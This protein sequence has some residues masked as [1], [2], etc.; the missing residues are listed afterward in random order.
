MDIIGFWFE[1][2]N[3]TR[4]EAQLQLTFGRYA[5]SIDGVLIREGEGQE[6]TVS[7]RLG[8]MPRRI[9]WPDDAVF[10]TTD[11]KT[12]DAWLKSS[13]HKDAGSLLLHTL[14]AS[15]RLAVL[16][17]LISVVIV[18][19]GFK[20]GIPALAT[21]VADSLPVSAHET[22]SKGALETMDRFFFSSTEIDGDQQAEIQARFSVLN[23]AAPENEFSLKLQF[24]QMGGIP[25]A[26]AFPGGDIIV[27]DALLD[28]VDHPDQLDSVLLHEIGHVLERHS[29]Q[30]VVQASAVSVIAALALGDVNGVGDLAA[31]L[32]VFLLQSSY[33]RRSEAE[34]D[35]FA[36]AQMATMDK[37][38]M[39]FATII[40]RLSEFGEAGEHDDDTEEE[41]DEPNESTKPDDID[42][43][44]DKREKEDKSAYFSTH[45]GSEQ[46]AQRAME[47][48]REMG[49][50]R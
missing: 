28:L 29:M 45:P 18:F 13:D 7:D 35:E 14:E 23:K 34:A 43:N 32:P 49:F 10:E 39:H 5:L 41:S 12:V 1:P 44:M 42:A 40:R 27:T 31:G 17:S 4:Q 8:N 21:R 30:H 9:S 26:M 50:P 11:N 6:I 38:P 16:G 2:N 20:W 3:S 24:R 46:R 25:N 19:A 48:S 47:V 22:I 15:W 37:D 36:F 33:S